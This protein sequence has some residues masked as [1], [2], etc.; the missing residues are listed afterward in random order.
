MADTTQGSQQSQN[1]NPTPPASNPTPAPA[2]NGGSNRDRRLE[3]RRRADPSNPLDKARPH[4][5]LAV[6]KKESGF[7]PTKEPS[8]I[9]HVWP[10]LLV[11]EFLCA[12]VFTVTLFITSA[13]IY[14]PLEEYANPERTPNPSKAPWYFLNLQELL[15]HMDAGLAGVIVPTIALVMIALVPYFDLGPGQMGRWFTS[16]RG[17]NVVIFSSVYT[18]FWLVFLIALDNFYNVKTLMA[19]LFPDAQGKGLLTTIKVPVFGGDAVNNKFGFAPTQLDIVLSNWIIPILSMVILSILLVWLVVKRF[20]AD[21]RDVFQA[22]FTGF[23][24]AFAVLTIVGTAFRG[25]GQEFDWTW[26]AFKRPL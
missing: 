25:Y 8:T 10:H 24:V 6:V 1:Q 5:L 22:L 21:R 2:A 12:I 11:I 19:S 15:L 18:F 3:A 26:W 7:V 14:A 9:V 13:F 16:E 17:K 20:G 23:V 4:R